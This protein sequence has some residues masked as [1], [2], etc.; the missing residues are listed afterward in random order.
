[1]QCNIAS[2]T[3]MIQVFIIEVPGSNLSQGTGYTVSFRD[4]LQKPGESRGSIFKQHDHLQNAY[5]LIFYNHL[6]S[7][8][9]VM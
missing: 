9:D 1:M 8:F 4:F 2:R 3:L 5:P 6:P 7:S